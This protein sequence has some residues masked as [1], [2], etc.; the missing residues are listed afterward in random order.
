MKKTPAASH[1]KLVTEFLEH[2][3][4]NHALGEGKSLTYEQ[5]Q[6]LGLVKPFAVR[7]P[8]TLIAELEALAHYG[9]WRSK[10]EMVYQMIRAS[11][12]EIA[13]ASPFIRDALTDA[14]QRAVDDLPAD[15]FVPPYKRIRTKK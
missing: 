5:M 6:G 1:K 13:K 10:Q 14:A 8:V 9:P 7:L 12:V 4:A 15:T 11:V 2:F 3:E